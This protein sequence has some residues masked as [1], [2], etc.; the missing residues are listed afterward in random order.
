VNGAPQHFVLPKRTNAAST[1][2]KLIDVTFRDGGFTVGFRWPDE[3]VFEATC[4]LDQL[5]LTAIEL[6]YI[7]GL[8]E[9]HGVDASGTFADL[10]PEDVSSLKC[11]QAE[12]AA[13]V[14]PSS[15]GS[16]RIDFGAFRQ[17]GLSLARFVYHESWREQLRL[18]ADDARNAGLRVTANIALASRYEP[19]AL[20]AEAAWLGENVHPDVLYLAD[21]CGAMYPQQVSRLIELLAAGSCCQIGF[22][23]HDHLAL[24]FANSLAA[25]ESGATYIDSS[26][27]GIGRGAG[28]LRTELWLTTR[29]ARSEALIRPSL[30]AAL[31]LVRAANPD[32]PDVVFSLACAAMNLTPPEEDLLRTLADTAQADLGETALHIASL[33]L[34]D[35]F[36]FTAESL[37]RLLETSPASL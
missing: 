34:P 19:A 3:V 1:E 27:L 9:L 23:A 25:V 35:G 15:D 20:L 37:R 32:P 22:H 2:I 31:R 21:T 29:A 8:P 16:N 4:T 6:G 11:E 7:G 36:P 5:G 26:L 18:L 24:A 33:A 30:A 28:N 12:L 14:H 17:A 10:K 13:M